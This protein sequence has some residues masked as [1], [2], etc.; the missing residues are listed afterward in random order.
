MLLD[1]KAKASGVAEVPP[2]QLV[3]LHLQATLQQLH[4]LLTPN[5]NIARDLLIT[6]DTERPDSVPRCNST[7][8]FLLGPP[9]LATFDV[10]TGNKSDLRNSPLENTGDCPLSCSST[11]QINNDNAVNINDWQLS[12]I[13]QRPGM[14]RNHF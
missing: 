12:C 3:L 14:Q 4:R 6:P 11:Y 8:S 2:E 7:I 1:T 10:S 5:S 13:F 9:T